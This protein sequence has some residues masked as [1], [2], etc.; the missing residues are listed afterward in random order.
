SML[1]WLE[2][3]PN[4]LDDNQ[5]TH[6][7]LRFA[8]QLVIRGFDP[9]DGG[10]AR[11]YGGRLSSGVLTAG[12]R[13]RVLPSGQ[14]AIVHS[15]ST[16]DGPLAAAQPGQS[17]VVGLDREPDISRGDWLGAADPVVRPP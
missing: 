13:I 6:A 3:A 12:Q 4:S 17:I 16:F 14:E 1:E 2:R 9:L 8:V 10:G 11:G 5:L 7:P 15:V